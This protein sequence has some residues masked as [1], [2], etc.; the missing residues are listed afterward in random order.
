MKELYNQGHWFRRRFWEPL[1]N[2]LAQLRTK[3]RKKPAIHT[4]I[5]LHFS[6][7]GVDHYPLGLLSE[8]Q[9]ATAE[10]LDKLRDRLDKQLHERE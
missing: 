1:R 4:A 7:F 5:P 2:C 10:A 9:R 3:R 6:T 8:E